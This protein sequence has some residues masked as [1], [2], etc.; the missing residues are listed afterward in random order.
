[1]SAGPSFANEYGEHER[2]K[3][4]VNREKAPKQEKQNRTEFDP[5]ENI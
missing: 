1:M 5:S 3:R 2:E 4:Y